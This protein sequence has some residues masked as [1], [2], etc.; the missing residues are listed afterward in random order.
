MPML[1]AR[2][3]ECWEGD[4]SVV[5]LIGRILFGLIFIGSG[6]A[7][8]LMDT[9]ST[10]AYAKSRGVN[11]PRLMVQISGVLIAAGGLAVVLGI[12]TDLAAL[13]LTLYAL[14]AAFVMH[15]FWQD[16]DPMVQQ[17]EMTMFMKN[18]SIAGGGLIL[19]GF[20]AAV[21][22]SLGL[23]ITGPVFDLDL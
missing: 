4:V 5:I 19:C 8:H 14:I 18:L 23:T 10:V 11:E 1:V 7:G 6:I 9:D 3:I 16:E 21:G 13:G 15:R 2:R 12:W 22:E 20:V 17:I